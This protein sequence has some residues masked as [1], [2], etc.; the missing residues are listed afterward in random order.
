MVKTISNTH[1]KILF[2]YGSL[3]AYIGGMI[4]I[5][6]L[7][8]YTHNLLTVSVALCS[9]SVAAG[10]AYYYYRT[11]NYII[12]SIALLWN[13]VMF[14]SFRILAYHYS[15][16]IAFL[17]IPLMVSAV[18]LNTKQLIIFNILYISLT[19]VLLQYGYQTYPDHPFLH[20]RSYLITF[21]IFT[22]F[23]VSFGFI[24]HYSIEQSYLQLEKSDGQKTLL[25]R[26][27]H[28]RIKNNLNMMTS[29][30]GLQMYKY[31]SEEIQSFIRQNTLRINSIALV[32]ELLYK[33][34]L[35]DNTNLE[36]YTKRLLHHILRISKKKEIQLS[37]RIEKIVLSLSDII[38]IGIILNE[39]FTNSLKYA[40]KDNKGRVDI[41]MERIDNRYR[42]LYRDN[43]IG[44]SE[45]SMRDKGFGLSLIQLSVEHLEGVLSI[46]NDQGFA[47]EILFKGTE[48]T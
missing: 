28:H 40:F 4:L 32:H 23:V 37:Y 25:L 44:I 41:S 3:Y 34:E 16:D 7:G 10:I 30:L 11:Q 42:L 27:I 38:H 48:E 17:L 45:E 8:S 39:L 22:F 43:G 14:V 33:E 9:G 46:R 2:L 15:I 24:Y 1:Y 21:G 35:I 12:T 19:I 5:V 13:S 18:L 20:N 47:C 31:P 29:I 26:E 36:T 6:L